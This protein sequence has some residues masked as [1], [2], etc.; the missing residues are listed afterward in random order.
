MLMPGHL[1]IIQGDLTR[2]AC[3]AWLLPTGRSLQ[4]R[5]HWLRGAPSSL[6]QRVTKS[7]DPRVND[8][9][10]RPTWYFDEAI[11]TPPGW[12]D[13]STRSCEMQEWTA[14]GNTPRPW[15]TS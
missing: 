10:S 8:P 14:D 13:G 9:N 2:L 7:D 5:S 11:E 4:I 15:L 3:D 12:N 1:F 6:L